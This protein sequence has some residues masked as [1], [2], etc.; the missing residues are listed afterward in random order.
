MKYDLKVNDLY[1]KTYIACIYVPQ[2]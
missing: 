2:I 1:D